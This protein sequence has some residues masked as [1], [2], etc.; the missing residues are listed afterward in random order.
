MRAIM[1][2]WF[3]FYPVVLVAQD[4]GFRLAIPSELEATGFMQHLL[5][6]FTLKHRVRI[7]R[8]FGGEAAEARFGADGVA[9]FAGLGQIWTL[10]H[11][12]SDGPTK[13]ADWLG[14]E[15]G[16]N[17]IVAFQMNGKAVFTTDIAP[18]VVVA[19]QAF[20]GDPVRGGVLSF[21]H[22]GRCHIIDDS[23][24]MNDMG[25]TPSFGM[26]RTLDDWRDRFETFY[27][28]NPHPSFTQ[29]FEITPAFSPQRP[30][31]IVPVRLTQDELSAIVAF[32]AT[33]PLADLGAPIQSQ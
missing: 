9:V 29:I 23:N 25:A 6:R 31:P 26:M 7:T 18:P 33:I 16:R 3:W 4:A 13:F 15:V 20:D 12:G 21:K 14:S 1:I 5:P 30:P 32:V 19:E 24:R 10:T 17:T 27:V 11:D 22:C 28:R 8:V 2:I